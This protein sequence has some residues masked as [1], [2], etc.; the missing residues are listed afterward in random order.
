MS[1]KIYRA[2]GMHCH[3]CE[4]LIKEG[5]SKLP[6]IKY[7]EVSEYRGEVLIECEGEIPSVEKLNEIFKEEN[8]VFS[9]KDAKT[10]EPAVNSQVV[11]EPE[12]KEDGNVH[13]KN[14]KEHIY[15]VEGMHCASCE[16]LIE[17]KLLDL[18]NIKAVD[19]STSS[20]QV[21][22]EYE[23]DRPNPDRLTKIFREENYT[24]A[25][26]QSK[27]ENKV[28][29]KDGVKKASPTLVAFNIAIFIIIAFLILDKM[30][31]ANFLA[32]NSTSSLLT[33]L[34]FGILAGMS[35]CAA[36][37]GGIV[38][39]MS[40]QWNDLYSAE[41]STSKKLQPHIMFN[42]GRLISYTVLG[43]VLG[44]IGSRL[45]ISPTITAY[46]VVVISFLMIA[47]GLQML[48]VKAFRKF[49]IAAP[50]SF[51][52]KI[53]NE[54]NFQGKYMPF[55]MGAL[56]FFLPCGF[57]ITAQSLALLSGNVFSGALIMGAF[58][59]G[60]IP[61]LFFI[62][63]SSV[64]FGSKPHLAERFLKVAGFLV[65]FFAL[66]NMSNQF[67]VLGFTGFNFNHNQ[68]HKATT[69]QDGLPAIVNGEQVIAMT[70]SGSGDSPN[71]FKVRAGVP[72]KWEIT[73]SDS[74]G[75]NGAII[76]AQLFDGQVDLTPGQVAVKEFTPQTA[77]IFGFSCTMGM[78]RGT[79]EVVD[80]AASVDSGV[81]IAEAATT[82]NQVAASS[83]SSVGCGCGGGGA[84]NIKKDAANT[85]AQV[86]G[87][88][89]VINATYT[90]SNYLTPNALE[91]K[92]G[93][94][95][96]LT[97]NVKDNG[98]GCGTAIKIPG[99]Y[100]N[101]QLLQAGNVISME[102]TPTTPGNYNI[103]CGM[104]MIRFG[105]IQVD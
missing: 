65:L 64:K 92:A 20:G 93:T 58:A 86:Q 96:K 60:T 36:L 82:N 11:A 32:L 94:K 41:Q 42:A 30:G 53:A 33:F 73:G 57:T 17:K 56:T 47:L 38:L 34:G 100:N 71:Y 19:A 90:A 51:T 21:V 78:I 44:L 10:S 75:C 76:S 29:E 102:F 89:Q 54:S 69:G 66:F 83:G 45:Q 104:G 99:L 1:Q 80:V 95:V 101:A 2:E 84:A 74:L 16:I 48:G 8:F 43:G 15:K 103:T 61:V 98:N 22:V 68:S 25:D 40:K 26:Q 28:K 7:I 55:V 4:I 88:T 85:V 70:A 12:K 49:Q 27:T 9:E 63:L 87:N 97:I 72:V 18:P 24:F 31:I 67:T 5:M 6:G 105:S 23:G 46:L 50:K 35:S 13:A 79:I 39:S 37:V 77:G 91:V 62:G 3:S 14:V 52:R 81:Q 59:L